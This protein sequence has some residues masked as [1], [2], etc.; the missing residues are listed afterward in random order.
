LYQAPLLFITFVYTF[1]LLSFSLSYPYWYILFCAIVGLS[2]AVI[3]Y[4]KNENLASKVNFWLG[5]LRF[6]TGSIIAFLLLQPVLKWMHNDTI[7]PTIVILQDNSA[8]QIVAFTKI[9]KNQFETTLNNTIASLE[10][11]Y[12][13][14]KYTYGNTLHD[15]TVLNYKD[16]NTNIAD[17]L[18]QIASN[19]ESENLGAIILTGDGI[20]NQGANPALL[21]M[22]LKAS[23]YAIGLGDTTVKKDALI[24]KTY[25]N[26]IAFLGDKFSV[27]IDL[28]GLACNNTNA[29]VNIYNNTLNKQ[30]AAQNVNF[31]GNK[32]SKQV[33]L[34][35]DAQAKGIQHF[36]ARINTINGEQNIINNTQDFYVEV[37]DSKQKILIVCNAPHPDINAIKE[38]LSVQKNCEITITTVDRLKANAKDYNLIIMHNL[39]STSNNINNLLEQAKANNVGLLF[40]VGAQ[41]SLPLFNK[42]QTAI[43]IKTTSGG[44]SDVGGMLNKNFNFFI[45]ENTLTSNL[46]QLPPLSSVFGQYT[47]GPNTQ[48]LFN[49][50]LGAVATANPLWLMQQ[51][52]NNRIG[53]ICAEGLWRWRLYDYLQHKNHN[54]VDELI[55][56]TVQYL[57]VQQNKKQFRVTINKTINTINEDIVFDAEVYNNNYELITP[58]EVQLI[59]AD[60]KGLRYNYTLNKQEK[61][62]NINI[63]A[64]PAGDYNYET[65]TTA[66]NKNYSETGSF[67]VVDVNVEMA[68]TTADFNTLAQVANNYNGKFLYA[69][70]VGELE[71]LILK[72]ENIKNEI[73]TALNTEPL[74]NWRWLFGLIIALLSIEWFVRK[75][76]GS[77]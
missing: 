61:N 68:N 18:E 19:Y 27:K 36:T 49:Q 41:T 58:N 8:S 6:L 72:N 74:I 38:A 60:K 17:A 43:N 26:K 64:L 39:P 13:V 7:K 55:Q 77:Y 75:R 22:P 23:V 12:I 48:V 50:K 32:C 70:Q 40:I 3:L 20:Y 56:K 44:V 1:L 34:L 4:L 67:K 28:L 63:G 57:V 47:L 33:E 66:N 52:G 76:S 69:N 14:K 71:N 2:F 51:S 46:A 53:V 10:K 31:A 65:R 73:Q 42:T 29:T 62:Y 11:K 9:N 16:G 24:L 30:L 54:A 25:Q 5:F 35:L 21:N 45:V 15:S 37:L 59:I